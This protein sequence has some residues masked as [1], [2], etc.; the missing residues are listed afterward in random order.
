MVKYE[1]MRRMLAESARVHHGRRLHCRPS[2]PDARDYKYARMIRLTGTAKKPATI[3]YRPVMPPVFDQGDRGSCVACAAA[4]TIKAYQEIVQGDFP[5]DGLSAAFLYTLCKQNDGEPD[6]E[7]TTPKTAMQIL[8][9]YGICWED[10]MPYSTLT[11]LPAPKVPPI[12]RGCAGSLNNRIKTYA[13]L[14]SVTD[15]IRSQ[16]LAVIRKALENEGPIIMAIQVY[17]NFEPD[18]QGVLPMPAGILLGGHA[19][20]IVGDLPDKQYLI[21]RNSWG[22]SWGQN[23]YAYMPYAWLTSQSVFTGWHVMEAWT[24][25]DLTV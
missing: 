4:W 22:T 19:V 20:G 13:Q 6:E 7:G 25:T 17:S 8:R 1:K 5:E 16:T 10:T 21:L 18:K 15:R 9:N 3:D 2:P 24:A 11:S 12:P 23:G 14:C